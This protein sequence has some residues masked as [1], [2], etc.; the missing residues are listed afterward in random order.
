MCYYW[1]ELAHGYSHDVS[2]LLH[3]YDRRFG[4][5][6]TIA[7]TTPRHYLL[8]NFLLYIGLRVLRR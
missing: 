1:L 3:M 5:G 4:A 6:I 7:V 2:G 8:W